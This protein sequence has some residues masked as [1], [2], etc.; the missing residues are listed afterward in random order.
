VEISHVGPEHDREDFDCGVPA[1]DEFLRRY[2]RQSDERGLSRTYV[3]TRP[4]ERAVSGYVTIRAGQVACSDLPED[5]RRRLPRYPVPVLHIA[6]LAVDTRA[7]G[8]GLGEQLLVYALRKA[9]DAAGE[10]GIWGVEVIAK[11]DNARRFYERYGFKRLVDDDLHLDISL[12]TVRRAL[13]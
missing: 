4:G 13:A 9:A 7:R 11:D 1:L 2:A 6:R 10:L 12:K 3:A 8:S 5:V